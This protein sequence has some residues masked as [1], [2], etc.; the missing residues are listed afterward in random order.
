MA[1]VQEVKAPGSRKALL[2]EDEPSLWRLLTYRLES[3]GYKVTLAKTAREGHTL[4]F[5]DPTG[6]DLVLSDNNTGGDMYGIDLLRLVRRD[7]PK[8]DLKFVLMS[9]HSTHNGEDLKVLVEGQ[10]AKFLAKPFQLAV[11]QKLDL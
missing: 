4:F 3:R 6:F 9:G 1:Q 5:R 10:G 7:G 2:V 8:K 11:L